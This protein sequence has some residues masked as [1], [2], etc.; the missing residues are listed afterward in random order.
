MSDALSTQTVTYLGTKSGKGLGPGRQQRTGLG[1]G[2]WRMVPFRKLCSAF[3]TVF[4]DCLSDGSIRIFPCRELSRTQSQRQLIEVL[5]SDVLGTVLVLDGELQ[6]ATVD[7]NVFHTAIADEVVS[8]LRSS[9]RGCNVLVLGG[10]D[11]CAARE[12]LL[13]ERISKC[14]VVDYDQYVLN[15][16]RSQSIGKVFRTSQT[17]VDRRLEARCSEATQFLEGSSLKWHATIVD[18]PD[19]YVMDRRRLSKLLK[20]V[21]QRLLPG[22]VLALQAGP[23]R[24]VQEWLYHVLEEC[25]LDLVATRTVRLLSFGEDWAIV[26]ATLGTK[27]GRG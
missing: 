8:N 7:E 16:F 20:L 1:V 6:L 14:V 15:L 22:G 19:S 24:T 21:R 26:V 23:A 17:F 2:C 9:V 25:Q 10:G 27:R 5:E 4:V 18:L 13:Q 12:L 11:G 3:K